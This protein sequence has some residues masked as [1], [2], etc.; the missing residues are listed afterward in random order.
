MQQCFAA[1]DWRHKSTLRLAR[2]GEHR[3]LTLW[4]SGQQGIARKQPMKEKQ[5]SHS[6]P[7]ELVALHKDLN[8]GVVT[9]VRRGSDFAWAATMLEKKASLLGG[10]ICANNDAEGKILDAGIWLPLVKNRISPLDFW[11]NCYWA[12]R[13]CTSQTMTKADATR[14]AKKI[15]QKAEELARLIYESPDICRI[16]PQPPK[17]PPPYAGS[18]LIINGETTRNVVIDCANNDIKRPIQ[19]FTIYSPVEVM[20]DTVEHL[21]AIADAAK[22]NAKSFIDDPVTVTK[23][24]DGNAS[25]TA[26]VF[27]LAAFIRDRH[28]KPM[29]GVVAA[30]ANRIFHKHDELTADSVRFLLKKPCDS[31]AS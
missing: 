25:R 18:A 4:N 16:L 6:S 31:R 21:F 23:P 2:L 1:P 12:Y 8:E 24:N 20:F 17:S 9:A 13:E 26:F 19:N 7:D 30:T 28:E 15:S 27:R 11:S 10:L 22:E 29:H 5:Y 14:F 3:G